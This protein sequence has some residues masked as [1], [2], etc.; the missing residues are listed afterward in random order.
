MVLERD[1]YTTRWLH[2]DQWVQ[3]YITEVVDGEATVLGEQV[4]WA[5]IVAQVEAQEGAASGYAHLTRN[6]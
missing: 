4:T 3:F 1:F 5:R 2:H 6:P